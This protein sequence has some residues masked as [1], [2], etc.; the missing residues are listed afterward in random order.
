MSALDWRR[1][2][3]N[4]FND[5]IEALLVREF[6]RDGMEAHALSGRGG[7]DGIDVEVRVKKTGKLIHT[8]QLKFFPGGFSGGL[9][10]RRKQIKK[11][12]RR[13]IDSELPQVWTLVTPTNATARERKAVRAMRDGA[14]VT[15]R[16]IGPAELDG[17]LAKHPDI[18]DR[19]TKDRS[20]ELL[21]ALHRPE[22]ALTK[23]G[24]LHKEVS[25]IQAQLRGRS[26]YWAPGASFAPD[27][28][29]VE[30]LYALRDDAQE[31]EP[32]SISLEVAFEP[33]DVEL[34]TDFETSLRFGAVSPILLPDR[35]VKSVK[36][37]GPHWFAENG[38]PASVEIHP[39]PDEREGEAALVELRDGSGAIVGQLRGRVVRRAQGYVGA[40][41]S[42][43]L[44]GGI[45]QVW[46]FPI[47]ASET[48]TVTF[49]SDFSGCTAREIRR[50]LRFQAAFSQITQ[51]GITVGELDP[52]W[53]QTGPVDT[54]PPDTVLSD[55]VDDL[56]ALE[57]F[58]DVSLRF[59]P[60][61]AGPS[62]ILWARVFARI[63]EGKAVA[64]PFA[65]SFSGT[66]NG[67]LDA[68]LESLLTSGSALIARTAGFALELF[69]TKL[70][71]EEIAYYTHA[72]E[73]ED[74]SGLL[75]ALKAGEG[76]GRVM[77]TRP[78]NALPWIIYS[79]RL[80]AASGADVVKTD[81]WGIVGFSEHPHYYELPNRSASA[82]ASSL[83]SLP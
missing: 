59:P 36:K 54:S 2:D 24:D 57:D 28:T 16:F 61:G 33:D 62:D 4:D 45:A 65:G 39:S 64:H 52:M 11:S 19:F 79:P 66:L 73:V 81:P 21:R 32:L 72:A 56:C 40:S 43:A 30:T 7:D 20:L 68:S 63:I 15:I 50:A 26:E 60:E 58:F 1:V 37:L 17:L 34:R 41:L 23:A 80:L 82:P 46:H 10:P 8:F 69:D 55:F 75:A 49:T 9:A 78:A 51:I 6:T 5:V 77:R 25:R 47:E 48:G 44:E 76:A 27:G 22:A 71:L 12:M 74:S 29:Y 3:E 13:S 83:D 38:G 31:R 53:M 42:V 70:E 67:E 14:S 18:E 35:V